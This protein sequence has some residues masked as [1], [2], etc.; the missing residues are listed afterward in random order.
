[1]VHNNYY[2]IVRGDNRPVRAVVAYFFK[3]ESF[4]VLRKLM[5]AITYITGKRST[6]LAK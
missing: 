3:V 1:M 2:F 4:F 5:S 6:Y